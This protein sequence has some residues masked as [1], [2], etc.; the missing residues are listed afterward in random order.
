MKKIKWIGVALLIIAAGCSTSKITSSW[1]APNTTTH[2]YSKIMVLGLI[3][4]KDRSLR[5]YMEQ[6][7]VGDL[8]TLGYAAVS[9]LE[10]YGPKAFEGLDEKTAIEKIKHS[11]VDA[12]IT[13]VLLD[14]RKETKYVAGQ[15]LTRDNFWDYVGTRSAR[16]YEP[17]YYITD[18][19]YFWES[20]FYDMNNMSL[21]YSVQTKSFSPSSNES[22]GHEYGKM[23]VK[24]MQQKKLLQQQKEK[25]YFF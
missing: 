12:V 17:G 8:A 14:K 25:E 10:E 9:S 5:E 24:N 13:I 1:T 6:H 16:L 23:I 19:K 2:N 21:L 7:F 15:Y 18:T 11:G 4:E 3:Q 22:M 20:N